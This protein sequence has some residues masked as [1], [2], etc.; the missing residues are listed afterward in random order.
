MA[1]EFQD[2]HDALGILPTDP[3]F[4]AAWSSAEELN[5]RFARGG[6]T[7]KPVRSATN[8]WHY[9]VAMH[10]FWSSRPRCQEFATLAECKRALWRHAW[11]EF[12]VGV[13]GIPLFLLFGILALISLIELSTHPWTYVVLAVIFLCGVSYMTITRLSVSRL[14]WA[15]RFALGI[16]L[17]ILIVAVLIFVLI[18]IRAQ[19]SD[20]LTLSDVSAL[21]NQGRAFR[22]ASA[23]GC[24]EDH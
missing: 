1:D 22:C 9:E 2:I 14:I 3:A 21:D 6:S 20:F 8:E 11:H 18:F 7:V 15:D 13:F 10:P 12:F 17:L 19:S 24:A 4:L 16:A 23:M 5:K